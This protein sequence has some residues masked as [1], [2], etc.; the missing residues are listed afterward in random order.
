MDFRVVLSPKA[1]EDAD[2]ILTWLHTEQAGETGLRWFHRLGKAI[3]SLSYMPARCR[4]ANES[5]SVG[6]EMRQLLFR[7][8]FNIYRILFMIMDNVV[9]VVGIRHGRR[10][11]LQ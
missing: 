10:N 8:R 6:F 1:K 7:T 9:Y 5:A 3:R 4:V 11:Y 2:A